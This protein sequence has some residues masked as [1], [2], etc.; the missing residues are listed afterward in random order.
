MG[1]TQQLIRKPESKVIGFIGGKG[2]D[3]LVTQLANELVRSGKKTVISHFESNLLP[4]TG[5]IVYHD[6]AKSLLSTISEQI[7]S[8][9]LLYAGKKLIDNLVQGITPT[10]ARKIITLPEVDYLLLIVGPSEKYSIFS[11]Q[12]IPEIEKMNIIDELV[13]CFQFD[14]MDEPEL[15]DMLEDP[16]EFYKSQP[17][18]DGETG[19]IDQ[20]RI[21]EYLTDEKNGLLKILQQK[22]PV[23][24]VLTDIKN[25]FLENRAINFSRDL[26]KHD[27]NNVY[28]GNLKE[29]LLKSVQGK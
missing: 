27:I 4:S 1:L 22:W 7:G 15:Q 2:R 20:N 11:R 16:Q 29:N 12:R 6:Q 23:T 17:V 21:L 13:Y 19:S 25:L 26:F 14:L 18:P 24:L 10:T 8:N 9:P 3:Y 28:L 5:H